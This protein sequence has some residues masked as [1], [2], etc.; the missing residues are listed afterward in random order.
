MVQGE[1]ALQSNFGHRAGGQGDAG[2]VAA[3]G[4]RWISNDAW[5]VY[6]LL[7]VS[8]LAYAKGAYAF[9]RC[10]ARQRKLMGAMLGLEQAPV[11]Q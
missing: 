2:G 10:S 9:W 11:V 7:A 1:Q 5:C 6:H 4:A 8:L 3:A